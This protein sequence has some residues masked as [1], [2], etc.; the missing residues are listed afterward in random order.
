MKKAGLI[1]DTGRGRFRITSRG[2][3]VLKKKPASINMKYLERFPEFQAFRALSRD[4]EAAETAPSPSETPEE[5]LST[6]YD[7]FRVKLADDVLDRIKATSPRRFEQ[8]V[9]D[10]LVRM[11]YGG[12][13]KDAGS[14]VGKSGDGGID[15]IIKEDSLGLDAIYVQAKRWQAT[16]G[17][18]V[19]RQF[20]G[21]LDA[22]ARKGVLI[23][24]SEFSRD[25]R[26]VVL[27]TEKRIVLI[28]GPE[29]ARL[30]IDHGVGVAE[31]EIYRVQRLDTGYFDDLG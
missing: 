18:P 3:D 5:I 10:L 24:T 29:L 30:M 14:V 26:D 19:V 15:G 8:I 23:T 2:R 6:M 13:V 20:V 7:A 27:G 21:S 4:G 25:A 17:S 1:E 28:D 31:G 9:I 12:S 11:G 22:R 16:V